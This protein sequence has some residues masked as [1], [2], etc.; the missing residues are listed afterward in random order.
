MSTP[1]VDTCARDLAKAK[2]ALERATHH[3]RAVLTNGTEQEARALLPL[4]SQTKGLADDVE[5]LVLAR[6]GPG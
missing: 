6:E 1:T 4:I 5:Q 2:Q 3:M